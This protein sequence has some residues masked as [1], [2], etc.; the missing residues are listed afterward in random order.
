MGQFRELRFLLAV[1]AIGLFTLSVYNAVSLMDP[2]PGSVVYRSLVMSAF[3]FVWG[4]VCWIAYEDPARHRD[5]V[6]VTVMG[7]LLIAMM[8]A[9]L[10][11]AGGAQEGY[12]S[13]PW[14]PSYSL[15]DALLAEA[16]VLSALGFLIFF[17]RPN[18]AAAP[19][20]NLP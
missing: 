1:V 4:M 9:A 11:F 15:E 19:P 10:L 17:F 20:G 8:E 3:A 7:L 2:S 6:I 14:G 16:S 12:L 13:A 18:G 5:L